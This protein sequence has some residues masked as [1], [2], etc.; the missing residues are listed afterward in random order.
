MISR[1][2]GQSDFLFCKKSAP[3]FENIEGLWIELDKYQGFNGGFPGKVLQGLSRVWAVMKNL[4][5]WFCSRQV[6][7]L[8]KTGCVAG[9]FTQLVAGYEFDSLYFLNDQ[10]GDAVSRLDMNFR[11]GVVKQKNFYFAAIMRVNHSGT[12]IEPEFDCR[13]TAR[14]YQTGITFWE[15]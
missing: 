9:C 14:P 3:A 8:S 10:L 11:I 1:L 15:L 13:P 7:G 5:A 2:R 12:A 6:S 4:L